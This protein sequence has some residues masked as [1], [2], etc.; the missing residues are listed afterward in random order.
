MI[1]KI[2]GY[3]YTWNFV[4]IWSPNV[5]KA[6]EDSQFGKIRISNMKSYFFL[7]GSLSHFLEDLIFLL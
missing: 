1:T 3:Y 5:I 6:P 2:K 7:M 4:F